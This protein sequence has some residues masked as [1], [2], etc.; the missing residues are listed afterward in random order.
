VSRAHRSN[1]RRPSRWEAKA[2][3]AANPVRPCTLP[4]PAMR[5]PALVELGEVRQERLVAVQVAPLDDVVG[6]DDD[7]HEPVTRA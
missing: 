7:V 2:N 5:R 6:V 1:C 3:D 4:S